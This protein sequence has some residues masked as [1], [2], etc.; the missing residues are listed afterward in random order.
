MDKL[1]EVYITRINTFFPNEPISNNEMEGVLGF[2][3]GKPSRSR[4]IVL[5][6]NGIKNRFYALDKSGKFNYTNA[7]SS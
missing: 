2:A 7:H 6:S 5:R 1:N 3:G 4:A